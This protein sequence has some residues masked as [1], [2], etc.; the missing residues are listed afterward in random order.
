MRFLD[1]CPAV[2]D[3]GKVGVSEHDTAE[4]CAAQQFARWG[5]SGGAKKET[6]RGHGKSPPGKCWGAR[7]NEFFVEVVAQRSFSIRGHE[8]PAPP[9]LLLAARAINSIS[10]CLSACRCG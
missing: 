9:V 8:G 10:A 1:G 3:S 5:L 7:R 2:H 6:R 4:G